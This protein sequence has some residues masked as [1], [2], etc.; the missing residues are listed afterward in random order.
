MYKSKCMGPRLS[1]SS[2]LKPSYG[3][4]KCSDLRLINW[5]RRKKRGPL[6]KNIELGMKVTWNEKEPGSITKALQMQTLLSESSW[7]SCPGRLMESTSWLQPGLCCMPAAGTSPA[8]WLEMQNLRAPLR[9][10]NL[11]SG[12]SQGPGGLLHR[13][14]KV[15]P[16]LRSL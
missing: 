7:G 16:W 4:Y 9:P 1:D 2:P 8:S 12:F 13:H 10:T 6:R 14:T 3:R 5:R 11:E 15:W